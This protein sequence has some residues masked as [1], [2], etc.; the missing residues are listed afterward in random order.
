ME[1]QSDLRFTDGKTWNSPQDSASAVAM[2]TAP[3]GVASGV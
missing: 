1:G 2:G 3:S